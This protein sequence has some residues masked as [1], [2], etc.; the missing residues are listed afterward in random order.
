MSNVPG[1]PKSGPGRKPKPGPGP[2]PGPIPTAL[3]ALPTV[4]PENPYYERLVG[5]PSIAVR[6]TL[7]DVAN[8]TCKPKFRNGLYKYKVL[9]QGAR[10]GK[11]FFLYGHSLRPIPL[12]SEFHIPAEEK[13][14]AKFMSD[15]EKK[16]VKDKLA[17][18]IPY[19]GTV[20]LLTNTV[21]HVIAFL[22][23]KKEGDDKSYQMFTFETYNTSQYWAGNYY[24][25]DGKKIYEKDKTP[26]YYDRWVGHF[27]DYIK[28]NVISDPTIKI[29][30]TRIVPE[31]N[32]QY[33]DKPGQGSC[34]AWS[35]VFL[36][37]L[38]LRDDI[39]KAE[40]NEL[41]KIIDINRE[42]VDSI[43]PTLYAGRR[44]KTRRRGK[45]SKSTRKMQTKKGH[46][47][48]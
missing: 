42:H 10:E 6:S 32:L 33:G 34:V 1:K 15:E 25:S 38:S 17:E 27:A 43:V 30:T 9:G 31:S 24:L 13:Y 44:I 48:M 12:H 23:R 2:D 8:E 19:L 14:I 21:N 45:K 29:E 28:N 3:A 37:K 20:A 22:L 18:G 39:R 7:H 41:R 35:L 5:I 4:V 40:E 47:T 11:Y 26:D 16:L 36:Y 46:K